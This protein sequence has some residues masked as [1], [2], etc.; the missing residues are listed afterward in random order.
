MTRQ[1]ARSRIPWP[2]AG[3]PSCP[4]WTVTP[5]Q[6]SAPGRHTAS[7]RDRGLP[8]PSSRG[9]HCVTASPRPIPQWLAGSPAR[10]RAVHD[11][12][13]HSM[14]LVPLWARGSPLGLAQFFRHRTADPFDDD[15]L[16]LAQEIASRAAVH[17]DNARRYTLE[18]S[19]SL[20]LQRSLLPLHGPQA[21]QSVETAARYV[22]CGSLA[23]VGGDWYDVIPLSG[24]RVAL[25]IGDVVGRGLRAAATMGRLRTAVRTLA[26]IDLMPDELLAHLND[27]VIRLQREEEQNADEISATCLYTVYDPISRMCSMAGAGHIAPAVVS[28]VTADDGVTIQRS[29][30]FPRLSVGPPLGLGGLPFEMTQF[31]MP[32][33]GLLVL[34]TD[35]LIES[36]TR[37]ADTGLALLRD[38]LTQKASTLEDTCDQVLSA[39]QP[40]RPSDDVALLVACTRALDAEHVATL[41][42]PS[43]PAVVSEARTYATGQLAAWNLEEM[44]FTTELMV[45]ELVTN[46]IRYGKAPI[47][48]RMILQ[49]TLTC[50]VSDASST[51]PHLRRARLFDE[52]GRGLF[53]VA[54]LTD[55]W[56]MRHTREGKVIWAEQSLPRMMTG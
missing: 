41:D 32:E 10:Q 6:L 13:I 47:Q 20:T 36:R 5:N 51:A 11:F 7:R 30:D 42:L 54:Q 46:A 23:G 4:C 38:V 8:R 39:L 16:L 17:I 15:D 19:T 9:T 37:D 49:S 52:G 44:A 31:E 2:C 34:F 50:E 53:L 28:P 18:R 45:S 22:P 35:G 48:L 24:G 21:H 26:D 1:C 56:G 43:D 25:V 55:N 3:S 12:G 14:L 27:V 33:G 29:V 40:D